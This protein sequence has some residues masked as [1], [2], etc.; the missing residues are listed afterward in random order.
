GSVLVAAAVTIV[1]AT[2][3]SATKS[4]PP[5]A[6][7]GCAVFQFAGV[8]VT[9]AGGTVPSVKSLDE[10]PIVTFAVGWLAS[11]IVNVAVPPPS[12]VVSPEVGMTV[13]PALSSSVLVTPMSG[14]FL[15]L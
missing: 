15:P 10:S 7:K 2:A 9:E 6:V 1:Y 13:I 4:D 3:P 5:G 8:N 12:V 14:A 11:A